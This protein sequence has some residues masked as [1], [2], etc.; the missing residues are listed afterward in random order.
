[1]MKQLWLVI[2][3]GGLD[4]IA[5]LSLT[6]TCPCSLLHVLSPYELLFLSVS[7]VVSIPYNFPIVPYHTLRVVLKVRH[8]EMVIHNRSTYLSLIHI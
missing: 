6:Y 8:E 1:M 5:R 3:L 2:R 7:L 4:E